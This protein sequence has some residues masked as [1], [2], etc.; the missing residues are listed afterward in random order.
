MSRARPVSA[1][2]SRE[3]R[4]LRNAVALRDRTLASSI[5]SPGDLARPQSYRRMVRE[6]TGHYKISVRKWRT[7]MAG[8]AWELTYQDGR[9]KR[10]IAA[11]RPR[12]SVSAAIF[13]HEIGHHA[14]GFKRYPSRCLEEHYVWQWAFREM[15][16][17]GIRI[18]RRVLMHFYRSM[19]HYL[20]RAARRGETIPPELAHFAK[21]PG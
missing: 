11:P 6:L 3:T 18:T 2:V 14:V 15:E 13:L 19:Y 17:R 9:I 5:G 4:G 8:S 12:G 10:L 21:W 1:P 7:H 16:A 20:K